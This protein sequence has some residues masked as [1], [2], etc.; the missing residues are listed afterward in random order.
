MWSARVSA[1][2]FAAKAEVLNRPAANHG[3][4]MMLD[5]IRAR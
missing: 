5:A 1:A 2:A 3:V 4:R